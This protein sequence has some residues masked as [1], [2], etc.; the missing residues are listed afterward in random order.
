MDT[1]PH[2]PASHTTVAASPRFVAHLVLACLVAVGVVGDD[3]RPPVTT[4]PSDDRG[5]GVP[6]PDLVADHAGGIAARLYDADGEPLAGDVFLLIGSGGSTPKARVYDST[7]YTHDRPRH[8]DTV[9]SNLLAARTV[10]RITGAEVEVI[11][12]TSA[13]AGGPSGGLTRAI[14]YLNALSEG[15]FTGGL[16]I[17]ATGVLSPEGHV[18]SIDD[19]DAKA[20][21]AHL[22]EADVLFTPTVPTRWALDAY[23]ARLVGEL[24]RDPDTGG[25]FHDPR[26]IEQFRRWGAHRPS[27]MDV[28]DARHIID[29]SSYLC[30]AG[31]TFACDVTG[32]LGRLAQQRLDS[33]TED[34]GNESARLR[35]ISQQSG[36]G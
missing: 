23:G 27:G 17:A 14:A 20:A 8:P 36:G 2:L 29:V 12:M 35:S 28:I 6:V 1:N 3:V 7:P 13:S 18:S 10:E 24:V 11:E 31:S 19:I 33:L 22:A 15:G 34:A 32:Q 5:V 30:G 25:S 4:S 16:R 21:A 26:R 9:A